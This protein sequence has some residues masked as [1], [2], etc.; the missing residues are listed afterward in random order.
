MADSNIPKSLQESLL[1][2]KLHR[3]DVIHGLT[4]AFSIMLCTGSW[5]AIYS[6]DIPAKPVN[7]VY[8]Y[9]GKKPPIHYWEAAIIGWG[10]NI[11][12]DDHGH[13]YKKDTAA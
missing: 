2:R 13:V 4:A 8:L 5:N 11:V 9:A 6:P 12:V 7:A 1:A 10:K 3:R